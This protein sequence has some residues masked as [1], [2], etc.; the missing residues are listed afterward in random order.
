[1]GK[2]IYLGYDRAALDAQY[3]NRLRVPDFATY[4]ARWKSR[5]EAARRQLGAEGARLDVAYGPSALE[6]LDIFPAKAA[7]GAKPPI[8]VFIHG[9]YW[10]A[11]DK[12]DFSYTALPYVQAGITYIPIN[13]GLT[14]GV[15]LDE[16]VRQA[17]A[18]MA[19]LYRNSQ[20]HGGDINR[21]YVSG[22]SAGGQL[23]PMVLT[24]DW[25]ADGLPA[26]LVKGAVAI[27]GL[28][29]LEPIRLSYL[30]E[31][32]N[33]DAAMVRRNSPIH[34]APGASKRQPPLVLC[35]GGAENPEFLRQQ[36][37][38]AVAWAKTQAP[39]A[40]VDASGAN[41]FS[42]MDLMADPGSAL[43]RACRDL[44]L[45]RGAHP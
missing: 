37:D 4:F 39:A 41:H 1:M 20:E 5:S 30:D 45:G 44:V 25:A 29:D 10:R 3:N 28:F 32:M 31:G 2:A 22:H 21:L 9:G 27:S 13:Y 24:H 7:G 33:L 8:L 18:A 14:P 35:V 40:A 12:A 38:Y 34:L 15:S 19:W 23:A 42:V 36:A 6:K 26:G 11:L 16:I 17:K 43:F